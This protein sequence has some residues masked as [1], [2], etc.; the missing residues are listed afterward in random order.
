[1]VGAT[2]PRQ[3]AIAAPTVEQLLT[4]DANGLGVSPYLL[5]SWL[6]DDNHLSQS[7]AAEEA[8]LAHYEQCAPALLHLTRPS[9]VLLHSSFQL[10]MN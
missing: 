2:Q 7:A 6:S 10:N 3:R 5:N 9:I 4:T 1:M 8:L